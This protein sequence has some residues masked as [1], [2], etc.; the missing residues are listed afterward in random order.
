MTKTIIY[1]IGEGGSGKT[2]AAT[3]LQQKYGFTS[4]AF[5]MIIRDYAQAN[6]ITLRKRADYA[7]THAE[8]LE[9]YGWDYVPRMALSSSAELI[10]IDDVRARKYA[11]LIER[12]GGVSIAFDCPVEVRF[13][14]TLN[15]PDTAKYPAT[16]HAF[17]QN[18]KEDRVENAV[19]GL[20][21]ETRA[22]MKSARYRIDATG[23][24]EDTFDQ[25]DRIVVP[26]LAR[27]S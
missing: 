2:S 8:I 21:F 1:L 18:E 6:G 14:H 20:K 5:G 27:E 25:L 23:S 11:E 19:A 10:C 26:L 24:L 12:A 17:V 15:H 13:A 4:Y 7:K 16:L 9:K 22:L 3:H